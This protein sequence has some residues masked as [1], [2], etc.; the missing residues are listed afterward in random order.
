[1]ARVKLTAGRVRDFSCEAGKTQ[2][3]LWDTDAPGLAI[4]ATTNGAKSYIFQGKLNAV[5]I[6]VTIGDVKSW[7]IETGDHDRPGAREE[8][9]R[10]QTLI[11]QGID[12]RQAKA[13][14][15][16][17]VEAKRVEADRQ[18][19]TV[20]ELW[21]VY[22]EARRHKWSVR[23]LLDHNNIADLGGRAVKRGKKGQKKEPGSLATLL[24]LRLSGITKERVKAWLRDET[25]RRPTQAAL[26]FRLLRAFLNWCNDTPAYAGLAGVDACSPRMSKENLAKQKPKTDC[27]QREQLKAWFAAVGKIKNPT[28]ANYLQA[29]LLTGAR[30]EELAWMKWTDVDFKWN[31]LTIHDKVE[32]ERVIPLTPYVHSLLSELHR[33]NNTPPK[34]KEIK[35]K[36]KKPAEK[37][38][39]QP[40]WKP[41]EWVF[42]SRAAAS[43]RLQEP[44]IQHRKACAVAGIDGM[45]LHGLR[46]SFGTLAE[47]VECP[48]GVAAQ[49]MGHKPSA[50]AEKHYRQRPLDLLR[51]WHTKIE[52]WILEEA[53]IK[54][55]AEEKPAKGLRRAK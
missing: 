41:S 55:S 8:A 20:A 4:R 42:S 22:I 53:G 12:P 49:I 9:R 54:I 5:S 47:W 46:R 14:R 13:E 31:S 6:R 29:L 36:A 19:L 30:R 39:P 17:G 23:H 7:D 35:A 48:T 3:F 15:M 10:L 40:K 24:P 21:P 18:D 28:I 38:E 27:L 11:D 52:A 44:S 16:A 26:A 25:A 37:K 34:L 2:T 51:A 43:G 45:T 1:V 32:G 50:T 33:I